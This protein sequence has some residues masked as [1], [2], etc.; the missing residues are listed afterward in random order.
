MQKMIEYLDSLIA[1][2]VPYPVWVKGLVVIWVILTAIL[3]IAL[4]F[5][6]QSGTQAALVDALPKFQNLMAYDGG[7]S[8]VSISLIED[9]ANSRDPKKKEYLETFKQVRTTKSLIEADAI[10]VALKAIAKGT[11]LEGTHETLFGEWKNK[12]KFEE[13]DPYKQLVFTILYLKRTDSGAYQ[14]VIRSVQ[15]KDSGN[16]IGTPN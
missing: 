15:D 2:L 4:V 8:N 7:D 12:N 14:D 5:A 3:L 16:K 6:P 11:R 13:M 10:N 1:F 9:I